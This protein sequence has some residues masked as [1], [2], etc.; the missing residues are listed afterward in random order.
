MGEVKF[1]ASHRTFCTVQIFLAFSLF[2]ALN[3][4]QAHVFVSLVKQVFS[5]ETIVLLLLPTSQTL[6]YVN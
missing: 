4:A 3:K 2:P 1:R 5:H 6:D